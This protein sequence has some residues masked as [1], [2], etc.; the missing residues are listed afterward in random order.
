MAVQKKAWEQVG[1][2]FEEIGAQLR[3]QIDE[4]NETADGDRAAFDKAVHALLSA[5]DDSVKAASKIARDPVLRKDLADFAAS[6][7]TAVQTT[8]E[9]VRGRVSPT[10]ESPHREP[11]LAA[12]RKRASTKAT[13]HRSTTK[14]VAHTATSNRHGAA[15]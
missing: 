5:L 7:R 4:A 10:K 3:R 2:S 6:V 8:F 9:G 14:K 12:P 13:A 11:V 15:K 1:K